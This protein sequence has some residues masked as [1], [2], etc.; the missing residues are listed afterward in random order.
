MYSVS[1]VV[2]GL[3]QRQ[4]RLVLEPQVELRSGRVIGMECLVRWHH[5]VEGVL[6]PDEFL[7]QLEL[8]GLMTPLTLD[9]VERALMLRQPLRQAGYEGP[10][11]INLSSQSLLDWTFPR[12]I[13][14]LAERH[15]ESL[16]G[17]IFEVTESSDL[18]NE[19]LG[20]ECLLELHEQGISLSLDDFWTGYS[21]L[22]KPHLDRFQELKI[23][24]KL[25]RR[26]TEDR[27]ALAGV[28][29]ILTFARNLNWRCVVEGIESDEIL[30]R[31]IDIGCQIGQGYLFTR[32]VPE[33]RIMAWFAEHTRDGALIRPR[34]SAADRVSGSMALLDAA[35]RQRMSQSR[36]PTWYFNV[37]RLRME[38]ANP[39]GLAFW[40]ADSVEELC[41]R[42]FAADISVTARERLEDMRRALANGGQ[43]ARQWTVFPRDL[44]KPAYCIFEGCQSVSG[45]FLLQVRG[46]EGFSYLPEAI[47][48]HLIA[49]SLPSPTLAL[50]RSGAIYWHNLAAARLF[51]RD[52]PHFL[53]AVCDQDAGRRFLEGVVQFGQ[54]VVDLQ[55]HT[56]HCIV[57]YRVTGRTLRDSASGEW[58][59]LLSLAQI[60]DVRGCGLGAAE[61]APGEAEARVV[62]TADRLF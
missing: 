16:S 2:A 1:N 22:S 6:G 50:R 59:L 21:S 7:P 25:T 40:L 42:D 4:F 46:F 13:A 35:T 41:G 5:P 52:D 37:D 29:S 34:S 8:H 47:D 11:S 38:W 12:E 28:S 49:E 62:E 17:R 15:A 48:K 27:V 23:D 57:W 33:D 43:L 58:S 14:R 60:C 55:L 20:E 18:S 36:T 45:D 44:P 51:A 54:L 26:V 31:L 24:H 53:S 32:P 56:P 10:L 39:A 61:P 30:S 19:A 9:V 3:R